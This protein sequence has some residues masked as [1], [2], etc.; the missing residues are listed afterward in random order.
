MSSVVERLSRIP[1][2]TLGHFIDEGFLDPDI[3][4]IF[5]PI[6][7]VGRAITVSAPARDNTIYRRALREA[8]PGDV[9]VIHRQGDQRHASFGGLLGLAAHNRGL[10]GAVLDGP[11]TDLAELT[12][13]KFPVFARGITALTA[14]RLNLGGTVGLPIVCGGARVATGDYMLGDDDGV[15][16][17]A[18]AVVEDVIARGLAGVQRETET[19][20]WL[21]A[22]KTLDDIDALR[23][24]GQH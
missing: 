18:A 8:G 4:P 24:E 11:V 14:R 6:R 20:R 2:S 12:A 22:G 5:R 1:P 19:R 3:R 10:A 21:E 17:I 7:L 15:M 23:K 13:L 16:V 9:L